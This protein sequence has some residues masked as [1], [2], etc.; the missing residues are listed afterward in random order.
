MFDTIVN[1]AASPNAYP[2]DLVK[3]LEQ[4]RQALSA[5]TERSMKQ[6][7]ELGRLRPVS[8]VLASLGR[9][10]LCR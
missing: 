6:F 7:S 10:L 5:P 8:D 9:G 4:A 1:A 3:N 2:P